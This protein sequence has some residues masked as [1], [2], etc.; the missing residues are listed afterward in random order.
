MCKAMEAANEND[1]LCDGDLK[2]IHLQLETLAQGTKNYPIECSL[3]A[4]DFLFESRDDIEILM[5]SL[6]EEISQSANIA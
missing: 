1:I 2:A 4:Y 5:E 6:T 3:G